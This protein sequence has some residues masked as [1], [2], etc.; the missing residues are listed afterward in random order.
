MQYLD[1]SKNQIVRFRL[2]DSEKQQLQAAAKAA[3]ETVSDYIRLCCQL[4]PSGYSVMIQVPETGEELHRIYPPTER[5]EPGDTLRVT[6]SDAD[7]TC[8]CIGVVETVT[9]I[10]ETPETLR[11]RSE[12]VII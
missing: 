10:W 7:G 2:T 3:G 1:D 4:I 11:M 5:L 9:P 6:S 8:D 12:P